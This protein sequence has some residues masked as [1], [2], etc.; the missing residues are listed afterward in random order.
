MPR[1]SARAPVITRSMMLGITLMGLS[2]APNA[3]AQRSVPQQPVPPVAP[4]TLSQSVQALISR[5]DSAANQKD[6]N[7]VLGFYSLE[8]TNSD[9]LNRQSLSQSLK[10]LWQQYPQ[11]TYRTEVLSANNKGNGVEAETMTYVTGKQGNN[12]REWN[13]DIKLKSRQRWENQKLVQQEILAEQ[14]R[15]SL[16]EKPP[17]VRVNLPETV[18]SGQRYEYEAI[19]E[20]PIGD[21]LVMGEVF[22]R[23]ITATALTQANVLQLE[24]P[25][26]ELFRRASVLTGKGTTKVKLQR[27]NAGGFFKYGFAPKNQENRWL[28]AVLVR[29]DAGVTIVTN[30][31]RV[32]Q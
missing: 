32:V 8:F 11:L 15:L 1:F 12:G 14:T 31:L 20:E 27:I 23:T 22:E 25:V 29:H 17:T 10:Q 21:D 30:R 3:I 26:L 24:I 4:M 7:A 13:V 18:K 2:I 28:S 9:G 19:M 6:L 5:I 16:G